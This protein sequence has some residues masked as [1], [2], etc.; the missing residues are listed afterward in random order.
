MIK[1]V[2]KDLLAALNQVIEILGKKD[3][4]LLKDLSNHTIHNA[5]VFQDEDSLSIAILIY[6]LS[7]ILI[8]TE[9]Q[10]KLV[11]KI[12]KSLQDSEGFLRKNDFKA[13]RENIQSIF[14]IISKE[15]SRLKLFIQQVV[16]QA[17]INKGGKLHEHGISIARAS[18]MLGLSRWELMSYIGKTSYGEVEEDIQNVKNRMNFAR[19]LF[20]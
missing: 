3:F 18:Q 1:P 19:S 6:A 15:D 17:Q 7:K 14:S 16:N 4:F 10:K 8:R 11:K 5:S 13:Y 9:E 20:S 12:I 2:I